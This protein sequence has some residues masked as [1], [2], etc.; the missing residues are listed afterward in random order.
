MGVVSIVMT[1]SVF[2]A[3]AEWW[4]PTSRE[5]LKT[6]ERNLTT[7]LECNVEILKHAGL[8]YFKITRGSRSEVEGGSAGETVDVKQPLV[9]LHGFAGGESVFHYIS[10]FIRQVTKVTLNQQTNF[11][12]LRQIIVDLSQYIFHIF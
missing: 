2:L 5:H 4:V 10:G 12:I 6:W 11:Y 3:I 1:F 9:M 7:D 8:S